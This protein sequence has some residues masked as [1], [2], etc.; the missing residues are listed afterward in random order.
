LV[1]IQNQNGYNLLLNI[2]ARGDCCEFG[3]RDP[4]LISINKKIKKLYHSIS[5]TLMQELSFIIFCGENAG[6]FY[7][8]S[9]FTKYF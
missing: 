8:T 2:S 9:S 3:G 7:Y 6:I 5:P 4:G 1:G